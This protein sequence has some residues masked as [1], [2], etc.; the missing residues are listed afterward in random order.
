M[1]GLYIVLGLLGVFGYQSHAQEQLC[2]PEDTL[3]IRSQDIKQLPITVSFNKTYVNLLGGS[4]TGLLSR[5]SGVSFRSGGLASFRGLSPRYTTILVD[6]LSAPVTEQ[7][8][9]AFA[10]GL[11][12]GAVV[13]DL[14]V[15]KSP[16]SRNS[17]EWGGATV[18]INSNAEVFENSQ[19]LALGFGYHHNFTFDRFNIDA[20]YGTDF[21]D[22]LGYG[23]NRL[24]FTRSIPNRATFQSLSRN[25]AAQQAENLRNTW[26]TRS[27][28]G[29]PDVNLAY[30]LQRVVFEKGNKKLS[31]IGSVVVGR[32]QTGM[33]Y[34]R[35]RYGGYS[36]DDQG[37]VNGSRTVEYMN[38]GIYSSV[39]DLSVNSAW[40]YR[41]KS[42]QSINLN[43]T[44]SN[45]GNTYNVSRDLT[46][47]TN[48]Q[49][50]VIDVKDFK[51]KQMFMANLSGEHLLSS[52]LNLSWSAVYSNFNRRQPDLRGSAAQRPLDRPNDPLLIYI[53]ESAKA[54][55]GSR[56]SSNLK[57]DLLAGRVDLSIAV[58]PESFFLYTGVQTEVYSRQFDARLLTT[59]RDDFTR[60]DLRFQPWSN[61]GTIF[62]PGNYGPD[63]FYLY[64]GTIN[65]DSYTAENTTISAYGTATKRWGE[66][67]VQLGTRVESFQQQLNTGDVKVDNS[68]VDLLPYA[69]FNYELSDTSAFKFGYSRSLNRPAFRELS[70][71]LFYDFDYRADI[72]GTPTLKIAQLDNIDL[73]YLLAFGDNEYFS[74]SV[75]YKYIQ[76]PIEMIYVIRADSPQFT[77]NNASSAEVA[78]LEL[79]F[80]KKLSRVQGSVFNRMF[81][82]VVASF[83][84][85]FIDLG[86]NSSEAASSRPL[87]GQ[88]PV[89][90][91][92]GLTYMNSSNSFQAT[93]DYTYQ[94]QY[95]FSVGDGQ[96]TFPWYVAPQDHLNIGASI[97]LS[98]QMSLKLVV[99]NILNTPFRQVEDTNLN[100]IISDAVDNEVQYGLSYQSVFL[101]LAYK[102]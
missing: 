77:F 50:V 99:T 44:Y 55:T 64:D 49:A 19:Q 31:T 59:V 58:N 38:D 16:S 8:I 4:A 98:D 97:D 7:N 100:A 88:V 46:A 67:N 62:T 68:P 52:R 95:L 13:Q 42:Q 73:S 12:P 51:Q 74:A 63:G 22:Y 96:E 48:N 71:F 24:D 34:N 33:E 81:L 94:G 89:L 90:V 53:P 85:S 40:H 26:T 70:P 14:A 86:S 102:F 101:T 21:T 83:T 41:W 45:T 75:F 32:S 36:R 65:F 57:D 11:L 37:K 39:S 93:L 84:D 6:G 43:L 87:Q 47:L 2:R 92:T 28:T 25:E 20:D 60:Y 80:A 78:G 27:A 10:L 61:I 5:I 30:N 23:A 15:Y 76:N 17:A 18:A 1:R 82:N 69:A 91:S 66:F 35:A 3:H 9:K 56:F 72:Q 29:S 54:N 79:E